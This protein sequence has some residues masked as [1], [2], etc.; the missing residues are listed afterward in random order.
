MRRPLY[1]IS[2]APREN[3]PAPVPSLVRDVGDI[4]AGA[5]LGFLVYV[6][7]CLLFVW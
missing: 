6:I 2:L 3:R 5:V 4:V 7:I 1:G